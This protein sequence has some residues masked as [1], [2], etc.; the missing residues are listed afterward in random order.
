HPAISTPSVTSV[1]QAVSNPAELSTED[2]FAPLANLRKPVPIEPKNVGHVA[3]FAESRHLAAPRQTASTK[4]T[5]P[6]V[7]TERGRSFRPVSPRSAEPPHP[8]NRAHPAESIARLSAGGSPDPLST[9]ARTSRPDRRRK[10]PRMRVDPPTSA[11]R[12]VRAHQ[13]S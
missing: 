4:R 9:P 8:R 11:A 6:H 2:A 10:V 3:S 5:G 13:R 12:G 7:E 1:D